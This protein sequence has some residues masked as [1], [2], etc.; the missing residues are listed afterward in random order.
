MW[1][2]NARSW[3]QLWW[4]EVGRGERD[5]GRDGGVPRCSGLVYLV[6]SLVLAGMGGGGSVILGE[7]R[8][9][10]G[11]GGFSQL[12]AE[13]DRPH[14]STYNATRLAV[15]GASGPSAIQLQPYQT[16]GVKQHT[17]CILYPPATSATARHR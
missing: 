7:Q 4:G 8:N 16:Q 6:L 3:R 9:G 1:C 14:A 5:V 2:C 12:A 17:Q 11:P 15:G 13:A 10:W